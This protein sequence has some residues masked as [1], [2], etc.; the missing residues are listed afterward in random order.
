VDETHDSVDDTSSYIPGLAQTSGSSGTHGVS[1]FNPSSGEGSNGAYS[2]T[3]NLLGSYDPMLDAD[4][5][6]LSASMHFQTP[7][8]YEQNHTRH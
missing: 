4:P 8:S 3:N 6:G 5:F 1:N 2:N 7:F